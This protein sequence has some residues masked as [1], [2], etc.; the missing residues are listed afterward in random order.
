MSP[1]SS[2]ANVQSDVVIYPPVYLGNSEFQTGKLG[3]KLDV[4]GFSICS[5]F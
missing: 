2:L 4:A 3:S 1:T 5:H